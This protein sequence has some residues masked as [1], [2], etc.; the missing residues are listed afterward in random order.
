MV[1]VSPL[2]STPI[3]CA[4]GTVFSMFHEFQSVMGVGDGVVG[5]HMGFISTHVRVCASSVYPFSKSQ[6]F[7]LPVAGVI[8]SYL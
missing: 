4:L 5:G 7:P 6:T 2:F 1:A 8:T 3:N